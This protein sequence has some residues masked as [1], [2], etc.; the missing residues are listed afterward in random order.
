MVNAVFFLEIF[1]VCSENNMKHTNKL[2]EQNAELFN[3]KAGDT[4]ANHCALK[5]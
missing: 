5:Y 4:Y 3:V 1:S 2:C